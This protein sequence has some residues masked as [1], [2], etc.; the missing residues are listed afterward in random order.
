MLVLLA[1]LGLALLAG[2]TQ[3]GSQSPG[4]LPTAASEE[5]GGLPDAAAGDR[6]PSVEAVLGAYVPGE[7]FSDILISTMGLNLRSTLL[8]SMALEA[9]DQLS[10]EVQARTVAWAQSSVLPDGRFAPEGPVESIDLAVFY[11]RLSQLLSAPEMM[12][13]VDLEW[14]AAE[15]GALPDEAGIGIRIARMAWVVEML[16]GAG[17]HDALIT[18]LEQEIAAALKDVDVTD[19][20]YAVGVAQ[21]PDT[22]DLPA[23]MR[24]VM[25]ETLSR[26]DR[27]EPAYATPWHEHLL[28][29]VML[30]T[31]PDEAFAS[32]FEY[33][34]DVGA[35]EYWG[36][37]GPLEAV[38]IVHGLEALGERGSENLTWMEP[39]VTALLLRESREGGFSWPIVASG[40]PGSTAAAVITL[41][42]A[43]ALGEIDG[44]LDEIRPVLC[45]PRPDMADPRLRV[46]LI[47]HAIT[48]AGFDCE[49]PPPPRGE[50]VLDDWSY[51]LA[52][53]DRLQQAE[54]PPLFSGQFSPIVVLMSVLAL[55]DGVR[56]AQVHSCAPIEELA[57]DSDSVI[58][59]YD[60]YAVAALRMLGGYEVETEAAL[61]EL[62]RF[63]ALHGY[64][65]GEATMGETC[66]AVVLKAMLAQGELI[67]I[68]CLV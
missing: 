18:E 4:A 11:F 35:P 33:W 47:K 67:E 32:A 22:L 27:L 49:L 37:I 13:E 43:D 25:T 28:A 48:L 20:R 10:P 38:L 54:C 21:A 59:V 23:E 50:R 58:G 8:T 3:S 55:E 36:R 24:D 34:S 62:E 68:I 7:G 61:A 5:A 1:V 45:D 15:A 29:L 42:Y 46:A 16:A 17:G 57:Y 39:L 41:H 30:G 2:C 64:G 56:Q 52:T 31:A 65:E 60:L 19:I 44:L 26:P 12:L 6:D 63:E 51:A 66:P 14:L 40:H 9:L 53:G